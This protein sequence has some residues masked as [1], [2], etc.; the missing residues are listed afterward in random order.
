MVAK[1]TQR[2]QRILWATINHYIATAEPVGSKALAAEYELSFSPATIRNVMGML[3]KAGLLYQPHISA[4]RVPSDSGYRI[5]V[6][7]LIHPS[8]NLMHQVE[9]TLTE[10]LC[11]EQR[12]FEAILRHAAQILA[13]MSGCVALI[14]MPQSSTSAIRYLHL[15]SVEAHRVMLILV[16]D[17]YETQSVVMDLPQATA[18]EETPDP[19]MIER[20]LHILNNFL[21][22]HLC[23]RSLTDLSHLDWSELDRKFQR[24]VAFLQRLLVDLTQKSH[25]VPETPIL[26]GGLAEVLRQPEF[27]ERQLAHTIIHLLEEKQDQ[28]W[29]LIWAGTDTSEQL[30]VPPPSDRQHLQIWIGSE[31]PLESIQACTLV[32]STYHQDATPV[33]SVGILGPTRMAYE[34]VI[35]L[36]ETTANY[37]SNCLSQTA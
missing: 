26:I 9:Q 27:A 17:T 2:Q 18:P 22:H 5:Y 11:P 36:V 21:N 37:L 35:A 1:L 19:E 6:D 24:H 28:L 14:T 3:E 10:Q 12:N 15:V 31:N 34:K 30:P 32:S 20:E 29:P 16:T 7:K 25:T 33:G 23:G 13:A 8:P 4:G